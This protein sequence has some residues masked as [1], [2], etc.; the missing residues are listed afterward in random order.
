MV[1]RTEEMAKRI[2]TQ[3]G[4][5]LA[6]ATIP[7][8]MLAAS[9]PVEPRWALHY[10]RPAK[11]W[12][13]ALPIGNGRLGAMDFGGTDEAQL[14]FNEGN[15]WTGGPHSYAHEGAAESLN[16][17]RHLL[18]AGKQRDADR[19]AMKRFMSVPLAQ[20]AYQP[21]ADL[22]LS[23]KGVKSQ[24]VR[25]Y[26][27]SLDLTTATTTTTFLTQ[28]ARHVRR[29]F[30]SYPAGAIVV[31]LERDGPGDLAFSALT[32]SEHTRTEISALDKRTLQLTGLVNDYKERGGAHT[33]GQVRFACHVRVTET[34][35]KAECDSEGLRVTGATSATLVLTASTN[36]V[37][38]QDLSADPVA[39]SLHD[40]DAATNKTYGQLLEDHVTDH[41]RLFDRVEFTL[42]DQVPSAGESA[43]D[44]RLLAS[45]DAQDDDLAALVFHYGRYLMIAS[46]RPGSQPAT[47]QGLWNDQIA[48]PWGSKY[49]ININTEMNYWLAEPCGLSECHEPLFDALE[50]LAKTGAEI[51]RVH[52]GAPGWVLHHNFDRWRGAAPINAANHGIWPTGGAWLCQHLWLHYLY[53]GDETFLREVA[54]PVMRGSAEF[55]TE[56]LVGDPRRNDGSFISGPSNSPEQGGL[57]MGPTMDHQIIRELFANTAKAAETLGVDSEFREHLTEMRSQIAPNQI[58]R[59]GQLQEWLE[60]VD[61]P[62]NKHRHVSHL[63][64]LHPGSEITPETPQ[65]F[66]AA[67]KTLEMRGDGGTGWSRAWKVNFWARLRDGD[68][69]LSVLEGLM[70]LTRSPKTKN[71]GGGLYTNLFDAHPP[72]QIDGNFGATSGMIEMLLQSHRHTAEGVRLIELLPALPSAWDSGKFAGLKTRDGFQIDAEW[73]DGKLQSCRVTSLL[74]KPAMLVSG[75][76]STALDLDQDESA[77]FRADLNR[78]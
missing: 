78:Q 34:D 21:T 19:L 67:R 8:R 42:G 38:Y 13:E 17:I 15:V 2:R 32:T 45:K 12:V 30:A 5:L 18:F 25:E 48:P 26:R 10:D 3:I 73:R 6:L 43:T 69:A 9:D 46:S 59:L 60:D 1:Y 65:F 41:R 61:K 35:G 16:E 4:L 63:W 23:F 44:D 68:H 7:T 72:F 14:Q 22:R 53:T 55:F 49:T 64:G 70:T 11:E 74:G 77:T 58:G 71:R 75:E 27:R 39:R 54:Y 47:L 28:D 56:Y 24:E 51:A 37:D 40:L 66:K 76:H 31:R 20:Q 29:A 33:P 62:D 36:V 57:V 50:E 52:Y